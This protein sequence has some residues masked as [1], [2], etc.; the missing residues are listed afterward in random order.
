MIAA[1]RIDA[2]PNTAA[3]GTRSSPTVTTDSPWTFLEPLRDHEQHA[4]EHD[5]GDEEGGGTG[6]DHRPAEDPHVEQRLRGPLL[7]QHE[8]AGEDHPGQHRDDHDRGRPAAVGPLDHP[9]HQGLK[10]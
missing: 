6:G 7:P 2:T 3:N 1:D 9:E 10:P 8:Q 4:G 5:I